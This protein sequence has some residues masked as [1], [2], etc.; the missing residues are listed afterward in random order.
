MEN[1]CKRRNVS[2][3]VLFLALLTVPAE[4]SNGNCILKG[5]IHTGL[6]W[7]GYLLRKTF[8]HNIS[9][10]QYTISYPLSE[11]CANMLIYYDDQM[12]DLTQ[13]MTCQEREK[14]LP[15]VS[16][17][18]IPLNANNGT[19]GCSIW[20]EEGKESMV[21]CIG[22]RT[23][24]SSA[25]RTWYV[26]ISRCGSTSQ[27]TLNY[28]FNIT[29]YYGR[30][31]DDPL[32]NTYI[33]PVEVEVDNKNL[34]VAIAMGVIAGIA[35]I[36][37]IVFI[38]LYILSRRQMKQKPKT[39]G[40]VTSSQATMTQDIFYVNPSLSDREH[41]D[42]QYSRSSSENYY[43]VIPDR[44]SYE[45]INTQLAL[46]GHGGRTLNLASI[47]REHRAR[48][49][50]Y[51]FEDIPPPPYQPPNLQGQ[52]HHHHAHAHQLSN[53]SGHQSQGS[54]SGHPLLGNSSPYSTGLQQHIPLT[55]RLLPI[56]SGNGTLSGPVTMATTT[57]MPLQSSSN[58]LMTSGNSLQGPNHTSAG[59][60]HSTSGSNAGP[61]ENQNGG[62]TTSAGGLNSHSANTLPR[63]QTNDD[64]IPLQN[65][66]PIQNGGINHGT[67][68]RY[69][70]HNT[71]HAKLLN[72]AYRIQQFET[73]A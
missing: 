60:Y 33:P 73:T 26:A 51:I 63:T 37:A 9:R 24:K 46:H 14:I 70:L 38:V 15:N 7:Y 22:E 10:I 52:G 57:R 59:N 5:R 47:P 62:I 18:V 8:Q 56:S 48:I 34:H 36:V 20:R 67:M 53:S 58:G 6:E 66:G 2:V 65:G 64:A 50:S 61:Q 49:P 19:V 30:C 1:R 40:S 23:L 4:S 42:S 43:E 16:N 71:N 45:S 27:M 3:V 55:T 29:G 28:Q 41:S 32:A 17:Q 35:S 44:R 13:D 21:V 69:P 11:C 39:S 68:G 54:G 31:E 72:H 25:P 12:R